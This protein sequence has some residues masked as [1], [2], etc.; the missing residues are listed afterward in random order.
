[1]HDVVEAYRTI[2]VTPSQWPGLVV[3]LQAEDQFA[4][5]VCN[6]FGL[7]SAGG[8]YGMVAHAGADVFRGHGI[9]PLAKWVNNH[10]FFRILREHLPAYNA[11]CTEWQ[12]EIQAQG[13][14]R[15]EGSCL[16][17]GGSSLPS[18]AAQEF[19]E[20]CSTLLQDL[21]ETS[22]CTTED[23]L[24]AYADTDIDKLSAWLG[25]RWETSKSVPFG[26]EV[27]YL[28]FCWNL[29]TRIIHLLKEKKTK[30]LAAIVE[31]KSKCTHN[32]LEM[33]KLYRKLLHI[34]L[35]IPAG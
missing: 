17:Y 22:P 6:N 31:W 34:S 15:Q 29:G 18:S 20:D 33:Q 24:F 3:R 32:L 23:L 21:A 19:D 35:V 5:N 1:M 13:G 12:Q 30:Y 28:G 8:M 16:W 10:V 7:T 14:C 26:M 9:S 11:K 4:I 25:I 27:L 2:P